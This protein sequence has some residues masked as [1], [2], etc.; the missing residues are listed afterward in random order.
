MKSNPKT[1]VVIVVA[2]I[3]TASIAGAW[4]GGV[5]ALSADDVI[6]CTT[7]YGHNALTIALM[8]EAANHIEGVYIRRTGCN[9]WSKN[10]GVV[11]PGESIRFYN[12]HDGEFEVLWREHRYTDGMRPELR[13]NPPT[14]DEWNTVRTKRRIALNEE[15]HR[16]IVTD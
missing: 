5:Q 1:N 9:E 3:V 10:F 15:A 12:L 8:P 13:E 11:M 16:R 4:Q 7:G 2:L 6:R 14:M